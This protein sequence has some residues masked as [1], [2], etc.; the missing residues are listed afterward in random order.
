[1]LLLVTDD[2]HH[3]RRWHAAIALT[4]LLALG[5]SLLAFP[6]AARALAAADAQVGRRSR[7]D[8]NGIGR[9]PGVGPLAWAVTPGGPLT[10]AV[11]AQ[12]RPADQ[13]QVGWTRDFVT[14]L[15]AR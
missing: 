9:Q 13:C 10:P 14:V 12:N 8:R 15:A 7:A 6:S 1:M 4:T 5:V 2:R 11:R 3:W